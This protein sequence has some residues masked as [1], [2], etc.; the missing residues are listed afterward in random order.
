MLTGSLGDTSHSTYLPRKVPN[1]HIQ[2]G[3]AKLAIQ[4]RNSVKGTNASKQH[5]CAVIVMCHYVCPNVLRCTIHMPT[6]GMYQH[7]T[8]LTLT[9]VIAMIRG[10]LTLHLYTRTVLTF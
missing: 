6:T 8:M 1:G 9:V 7:L 5:A 4:E 2:H 10:S 3:I